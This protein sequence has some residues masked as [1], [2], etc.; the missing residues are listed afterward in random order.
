MYNT[1]E[2]SRN[3]TKNMPDNP[4]TYIQ[5]T[6]LMISLVT[7]HYVQCMPAP[8]WPVT[9]FSREVTV[10][11]SSEQRAGKRATSNIEQ[12]K[13]LFKVIKT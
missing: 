10:A 8:V 6:L 5:I 2:R 4:D 1:I 3:C 11:F 13:V 12:I 7:V 9:L